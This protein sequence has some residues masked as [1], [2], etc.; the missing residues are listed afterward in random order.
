MQTMLN[1]LDRYARRKHL[2]INTAKSEVAHFNLSGSNLPVF[3]VDGEP[4][5]HKESLKYLGMWSHKI[6]S[7]AKSSEHITGPF[8]ASA[9]RIR[10]FVQEHALGDRPDVPLWLGKTYLVPAGMYASQVRGAEYV[11]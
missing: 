7:M 9:Y 10:Q 3:S 4:L 6:I 8:M 2:L 5:A 1:C 11:K